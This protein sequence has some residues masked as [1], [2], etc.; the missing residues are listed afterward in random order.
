MAPRP[1]SPLLFAV[2]GL[3]P[4]ASGCLPASAR[5]RHGCEVE[6]P[7]ARLAPRARIEGSV[8]FVGPAR[9]GLRL[10][11][12]LGGDAGPTRGALWI[13]LGGVRCGGRPL[14]VSARGLSRLTLSARLSLEGGEGASAY[15]PSSVRLA[16]RGAAG[17][18]VHL[19]HARLERPAGGTLRLRGTPWVAPFP[20]PLGARR[21]SGRLSPPLEVGVHLEAGRREGSAE[22]WR[23]LLRSLRLALSDRPP[24]SPRLPPSDPPRR[25]LARARRMEARWRRRYGARRFVPGVNLPHPAMRSPGGEEVPLY[26][27]WLDA[28]ERWYGRRPDLRDPRVA[29]GLRRDLWAIRE[30]LGPGALVRL[31]LFADLRAGLRFAP[32]GTPLEVSER[33]REGFARLLQMAERSDV[34][35]MPVLFDFTLAD[36]RHREGPGGRWRVGE[37]VDLVLSARKR[38]RLWDALASF[39]APFA[40]HR[41]ILAWDLVNEPMHAAAVVRPGR[42]SSWLRF[43][44]EGADVLGRTGAPLTLGYRDPLV[45]RWLRGR[46]PLHLG[47]AHF[48]PVLD[49]IPAPFGP[50]FSAR[51]AFGPLPGG[52][53]ELPLRP[54]RLAQDL[55]RAREAGHRFALFWS[56]RGD[57]PRADGLAV[58]PHESLLRRV[59]GRR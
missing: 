38:R 8:E 55:R 50:S 52:W 58:R 4:G 21:G 37:R 56:W 13:P 48:Y 45:A 7:L 18:L 25:V 16:L 47:Q 24:R 27:V 3:V 14:P 32:D 26:G 17:G 28:P 54:G 36:G 12:R 9:G 10:R 35:L 42:L 59:A 11:V 31:F 2:L 30:A 19:P 29:A 22:R 39:V 15:R 43:L 53:G 44:R 57:G 33:A 41:A 23:L 5:P 6:L 51:H 1:V 20:I 46:I 34:V 49:G 40:R